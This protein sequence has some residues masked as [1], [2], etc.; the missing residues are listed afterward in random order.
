M[1]SEQ[2]PE[3]EKLIVSPNTWMWPDDDHVN[4]HIEIELPGAEKESISLK[5]HEDS[6]FIKA[7]T[8]D[9][10]FVGSYTVCCEID[11]EKA[12]AKYK[13]G[14]LKVDVP[15]KEEEFHSVKIKIE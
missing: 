12:V 14:L 8:E 1:M 13:N 10:V 6:F 15:F 5:M 9:T 7:E 2:E 11:P 4:Y 3:I